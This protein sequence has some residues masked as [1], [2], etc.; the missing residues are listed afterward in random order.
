[1]NV[2]KKLKYRMRD[3]RSFPKQNSTVLISVVISMISVLFIIA[4]GNGLANNIADQLKPTSSRKLSFLYLGKQ[5]TSLKNEDVTF[6]KKFSEVKS[7]QVSSDEKMST[8]EILFHNN[9]QTQ[10]TVGKINDFST[11]KVLQ[12]NVDSLNNNDYVFINKSALWIRPSNLNSLINTQIYLNDKGYKISGLYTTNLLDG[13]NIPDILISSENFK[14]L[15]LH[16]PNNKLTISFKLNS[17]QD[18]QKL[19]DKIMNK[20]DELHSNDGSLVVL[21]DTSLSKSMHNLVNR[22]ALSV[23]IVASIS[24]VI[25]G[26]S[27][28]SSMYAN[29][30]IRSSEIGL[31]RTLGATRKNIRN[32][33]IS[34]ALI[35]LI[36]GVLIGDIVSQIFILIIRSFGVNTYITLT[37]ML[38]I[39]LI[40]IAIGFISSISPATIAAN[41][42]ITDILRSE[43]N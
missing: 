10:A 9:Q 3:I 1:M 33:F 7:F 31:R 40:P 12:G 27:I 19:E 15:G 17:K 21:D 11:V 41:K 14:N 6:L 43:Y 5:Q 16:V 2:I 18:L 4:L 32:Q 34:E 28:S 42:N 26:F 8:T 13:G 37:E 23:V 24:L 35:L 30:A 39:G 25:S 38:L 22:I 29:I 36:A 20:Y